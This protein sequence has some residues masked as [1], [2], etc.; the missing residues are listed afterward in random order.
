MVVWWPAWYSFVSRNSPENHYEVNPILRYGLVEHKF[1]LCLKAV[2]K[3]PLKFTWFGPRSRGGMFWLVWPTEERVGCLQVCVH[4]WAEVVDTIANKK[5]CWCGLMCCCGMFDCMQFQYS[6]LT[7]L[8]SPP[9]LSITQ[10]THTKSSAIIFLC[11]RT[12]NVPCLYLLIVRACIQSKKK[13][14]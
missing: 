9:V 11:Y 1:A 8:Y 7:V 6:T 4:L 5:G 13:T 3:C 14:S 2:K 12:H 10:R